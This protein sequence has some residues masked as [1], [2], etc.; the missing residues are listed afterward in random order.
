MSRIRTFGRRA[1]MQLARTGMLLGLIAASGV[2]IGL[3]VA[4]P[5]RFVEFEGTSAVQLDQT[6]L[7]G[8]VDPPAALV[9]REDLP[10]GWTEGDAALAGFGILGSTFCGEDVTLPTALSDVDAAVWANGTDRS[11]LISQAVRVDRWQSAREYVDDVADALAGC[12]EFFRVGFGAR[13]KVLVKDAGGQPLVSDSVRAAFVSSDGRSVVEWSIMA[14]GDVVVGIS[15]NGP[16]RPSG[17]FLNRV[18][19]DVLARI[20]PDEFAPGGV[21]PTTTVE[22]EG[23]DTTGLGGAADESGDTGAEEP[24]GEEPVD[25]PPASAETGETGD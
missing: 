17:S 5:L 23:A 18:E 11:T 21:A 15:H 8:R 7:S 16:T 20:A 13:E 6:S 19:R 10:S 24:V 2:V 4:Y 1:G 25:A 14:V 12:D 9:T 3:V 22:G